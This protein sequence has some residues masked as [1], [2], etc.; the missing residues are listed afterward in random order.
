MWDPGSG[1][2]RFARSM[3]AGLVVAV[4][5]AGSHVFGGGAAHSSWIAVVPA[6]LAV[7]AVTYVLGGQRVSAPA[8][9]ALLASAQA[10]VHALSSYLH[11]HAPWRDDPAMAL[12]H[13]AAVVVSALLLA[14]GE[15]VLWRLHAWL[16]RWRIAPAGATP[17]LRPLRA[18]TSAPAPARP[19]ILLGGLSRRG[20]PLP[21]V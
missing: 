4:V 5:A 18:A 11:A 21:V 1:G 17:A 19:V 6:A 12:A 9:A 16:R 10:G 2:V 7:T 13:L 20:P 14:R 8:L 3:A 15:Q